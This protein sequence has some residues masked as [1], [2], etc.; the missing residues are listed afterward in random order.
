MV[1]YFLQISGSQQSDGS[2]RYK[3]LIRQERGGLAQ[4]KT[5]ESEDEMISTMNRIFAS[6][7]DDADVRRVL[8]R[9]KGGSH[10]WHNLVL[11]D[12]QAESLGWNV[13][14]KKKPSK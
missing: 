12:E 9:I 2:Y 7:K 8:D 14:K 11:T 5:F 4:T 10:Q 3:T 13:A 1:E 6:R